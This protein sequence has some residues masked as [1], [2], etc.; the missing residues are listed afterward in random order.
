[1]SLLEKLCVNLV[2]ASAR[3]NQ[4]AHFVETSRSSGYQL[5]TVVKA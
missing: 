2:T 1:M 4:L 5:N 3:Q